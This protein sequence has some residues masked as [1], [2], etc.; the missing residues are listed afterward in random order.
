MADS[1]ASRR[2]LMVTGIVHTPNRE[3]PYAVWIQGVLWS[4]HRTRDEAEEV[5]K[6][7]RRRIIQPID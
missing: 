4:F 2:S 5:M 7:L 6:G 3:Q 1:N